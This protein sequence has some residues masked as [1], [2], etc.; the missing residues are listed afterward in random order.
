M[1]YIRPSKSAYTKAARLLNIVMTD[2]EYNDFG[3][4]AMDAEE[5][6]S[7]DTKIVHKTRIKSKKYVEH[8]NDS[9]LG[10]ESTGEEYETKSIRIPGG[11]PSRVEG[12]RDL[13]PPG[14]APKTKKHVVG[15]Q[16][17]GTK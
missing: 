4:T 16:K 1:V 11:P 12:S 13:K 17:K 8:Q 2:L 5:L 6:A 7:I 3:F 15:R 10:P 14:P 9:V